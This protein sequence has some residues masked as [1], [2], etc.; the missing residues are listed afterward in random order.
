M[1]AIP[2][3]SGTVPTSPNLDEGADPAMNAPWYQDYAAYLARIGESRAVRS[4]LRKDASTDP[5]ARFDAH[6]YLAR[7]VPDH[8]LGTSREWAVYT[9]A[10]LYGTHPGLNTSGT[11]LSLGAALG[12]ISGGDASSGNFL[13]LRQLA[14][15]DV[16]GLCRRLIP[17][18]ALLG[19]KN[20]APD[21]AL[22]VRDINAWTFDRDAV[23]Q[24]WV[25]DFVGGAPSDLSDEADEES[26][27]E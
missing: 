25:R 20:A 7:W 18:V 22:I 4:T 2:T 13:R 21:L 27:I 11:G 8:L 6:P 15:S 9:A 5:K 14:N 17:V 1:I 16:A 3:S 24:R 23:T 12:K 26:D 19:S 10:V